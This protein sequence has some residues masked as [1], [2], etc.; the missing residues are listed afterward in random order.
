MPENSYPLSM[1]CTETI[2]KQMNNSLYKLEEI[3][4]KFWVGFF[5]HIKYRNKKI[6]VL[7]TTYPLFD[8]KYIAQKNELII[9][10]NN[11]EEIIIKLGKTL[12]INRDYSILVIDVEENN[13]IEFLELDEAL[14][15]KEPEKF[16]F[17][18]PIYIIHCDKNKNDNY[19]SY[20]NERKIYKNELIFSCNMNNIYSNS[21]PIF[22]QNNNKIIGIFKNN[23]EN[24]NR[25]LFFKYIIKEFIYEYINQNKRLN[26]SQNYKNEIDIFFDIKKEDINKDIYFL[27]KYD[28]LKELNIFKTDIYLNNKHIKNEDKKKYF[29]SDK[30][31]QFCIK[32][33][34]EGYLTDISYIFSGCEKIK[35]INFISFY[36]NY[37]TN[38]EYM[39]YECINL[40]NIKNLF[41]FDTEN[42]L[43]MSYMFYQCI[44][45]INFDL[46]SFN[47]T[48][49]LNMSNMF[50][51]CENLKYIDLSSF[52]TSKVV[53]L[54]NMF[55]GCKNLVNVDLSSFNTK[56]VIDMRYIFNDCKNLVNL[57]L[58]SFDFKNVKET[59]HMFFGCSKLNNL[60][61]L[62][63][64]IKNISNRDKE[65]Y[66]EYIIQNKVKGDFKENPAKLKFK[67]D[68]TN[69]G[70]TNGSI[71]NFE[72]F[73]GLKDKKEYIVYQNQNNNLEIMRII[74][75]TITTSLKGAV[76]IT[77]IKY[78]K[79]DI[80]EDFLLSC[81]Y[82][83]SIIIWDIQNN[84]NIKYK[85]KSNYFG[86]IHYALLLFNIYNEDYILLSSTNRNI[87]I[88]YDYSKLYKF[89]EETPFVKDIYNT[90]TNYT[91]YMIPWSYNKK[92][93]IIEL[94]DEKISINNLFENENYAVLSKEPEGDHQCGYIYNENYLCVSDS[95]NSNIRIWDLVNKTVN[96]QIDYNENYGYE[97]IQWNNKYCIVGGGGCFL[98]IDI[99]EGKVVKYTEVKDCQVLGI[100]KIIIN[101]YGECLIGS[102][103]KNF[104]LIGGSHI[105]IKLF[106]IYNT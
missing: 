62:I 15:E 2:L 58:S 56:N 31:G 36:T 84:F 52:N 47:T 49:V 7:I 19:V 74:D 90:D 79:K 87:F 65:I 22:N 27:D 9:Y 43:N 17:N 8:L 63:L 30:E 54:S 34:F 101:N 24:K 50:N 93:Y 33:I 104:F 77:F 73:I 86:L 59:S 35:E 53:D 76:G 70:V 102:V 66:E 72:V 64:N 44:N 92:Y 96:K 45:L 18:Q 3:N 32:L 16:Y 42:V 80:S 81:D 67:Y 51:G 40:K 69:Y 57:N 29:K 21:S 78:F 11:G 94:C 25:G 83:H 103:S 97:T 28:N 82:M 12:Y 13:K 71:N 5:C 100:K 26:Y 60:N 95:T 61:S 98:I 6:P 89:K 38:M 4:G 23:S 106:S 99:E 88:K 41:S 46:S 14:Y 37:I 48:N 10:K 105:D 39:F 68:L 55:N 85:F 1:K 20:G 75:K 91:N